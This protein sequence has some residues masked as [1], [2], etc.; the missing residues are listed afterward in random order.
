MDW[1]LRPPALFSE[2]LLTDHPGACDSALAHMLDGVVDEIPF[3][4]EHRAYWEKGIPNALR[5]IATSLG[6]IPRAVQDGVFGRIAGAGES[7]EVVQQ[8]LDKFEEIL[9]LSVISQ[10]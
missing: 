3:Y 1:H 8:K 7:K 9:C 2:G 10:P 4:F 5:P 6:L